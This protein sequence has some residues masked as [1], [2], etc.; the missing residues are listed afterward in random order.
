[1]SEQIAAPLTLVPDCKE[2]MKSSWVDYE[3]EDIIN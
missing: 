3:L 1:M 2:Y